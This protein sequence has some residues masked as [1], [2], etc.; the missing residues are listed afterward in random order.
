MPYEEYIKI[1][2]QETS[3]FPD[4]IFSRSFHQFSEKPEKE[5]KHMWECAVR[6]QRERRLQGF[7]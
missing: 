1:S 3:S 6:N 7:D 5:Q 2:W 4:E